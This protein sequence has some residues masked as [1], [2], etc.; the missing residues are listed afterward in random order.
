MAHG[1]VYDLYRC[2]RAFLA[3]D[4]NHRASSL[5][6]TSRASSTSPAI[7][8]LPQRLPLEVN[9]VSVERIITA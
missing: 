1:L 5:R 3:C 8:Y 4:L 6:L 7:I 2:A 9:A